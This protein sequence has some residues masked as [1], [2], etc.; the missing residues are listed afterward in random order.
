MVQSLVFLN[1]ALAW[2]P[3]GTSRVRGHHSHITWCDAERTRLCL[4]S[5][6]FVIVH[7]CNQD[8]RHMFQANRRVLWDKKMC[9]P[10][11]I[12]PC[13]SE[14]RCPGIAH[15]SLGHDCGQGGRLL[16]VV[17]VVTAIMLVCQPMATNGSQQKIVAHNAIFTTTSEK[18]CI[19][20][21]LT[22]S[23]TFFLFCIFSGFA[24]TKFL[25][26]N[27]HSNQHTCV[28]TTFLSFFLWSDGLRQTKGNKGWSYMTEPK[29][30]HAT[31]PSAIV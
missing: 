7:L 30:K 2:H 4:S 9:P 22:T 16:W 8:W 31:W 17:H 18:V 14:C 28:H 27:C 3:A 20:S 15:H 29:G 1:C 24:H 5:W 12:L 23:T 6:V 10:C 13:T 21:E 19:L 26:K 11:R 25:D